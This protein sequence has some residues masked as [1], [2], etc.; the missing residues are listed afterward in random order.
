MKSTKEIRSELRRLE[1]L[2]F[3]LSMI[4]GSPHADGQIYALRWVLS[5]TGKV[6]DKK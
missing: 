5:K 6:S 3:R 4:G 1:K 2:H